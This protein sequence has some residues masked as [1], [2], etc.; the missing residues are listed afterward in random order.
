MIPKHILDL[1][2]ISD[3]TNILKYFSKHNI[4]I[5]LYTI[6][7]RGIIIKFGISYKNGFRRV[8]GDRIYTQAGYFPGWDKKCLSRGP[9]SKLATE[10]IIAYLQD[11]YD[12][13]VH[14]NDI[15][16]EIDDYTN[17]NFINPTNP[18]AEMQNEEERLKQ[19]FF[20]QYDRYPIGNKKQ[21]G[22]RFV[23]TLESSN[24]FCFLDE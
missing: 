5:Y 23:T 18:Y 21:E 3:Y 11:K 1:K 19:S 16:I 22:I 13:I 10:E 4:E 12:T 9:K 20:N 24:L 2:N 17:Y 6:K 7:W 15:V 14:K 8:M